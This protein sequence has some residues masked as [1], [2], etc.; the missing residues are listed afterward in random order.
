MNEI[1][2]RVSVCLEKAASLRSEKRWSEAAEAYAEL[3][4]AWIAA[5]GIATSASARAERLTESEKMMKLADECKSKVAKGKK[6]N[7][8]G[9]SLQNGNLKAEAEDAGPGD[10]ATDGDDD[11][12]DEDIGE[13]EPLPELLAQLDSLIGLDGVK[14]QVRKMI[15][16]LDLRKKREAEGLGNPEMSNHLVF[17]G[18]PGTGKTTVARLIAKIYRSMGILKKGQ[19]VE[20]DRSGLVSN[21]VG[22]TALNTKAAAKKAKGG[23]LFIDEAYALA[24]EGNDFGPEAIDTLLKVMEDKRDELVVIVAGYP[25]LMANFINRTNPGLPS[26]FRNTI[27]FEDYSADDLAK[28]FAVTAEKS[29]YSPTKECVDAVRKHYARILVSPPKNFGNARLVRNLFEDALESLSL[30]LA[31][32][33]KNPSVIEMKTLTPQ[34]VAGPIAKQRKGLYESRRK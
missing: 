26:R 13:C 15:A 1:L 12:A 29:N 22:E 31:A 3:A 28:I 4:K 19:L 23:V 21:H 30:R 10:S 24:K 5:A 34:D 2:K 6:N 7:G 9:R 20:T 14:R 17:T 8:A 33:N 25:D 32:T 16:M 18:N 27:H 11:S